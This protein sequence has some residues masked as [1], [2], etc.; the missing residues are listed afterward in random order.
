MGDIK[1][2]MLKSETLE[3]QAVDNSKEQFANSP[4]ILKCILN[5]IMD[6]GEAH[7]SLS[8]Q[9]LNS[10]KVR[11]GLKDILLGPGQLWE[12]LRQQREQEDIS[13]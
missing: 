9:A 7:S 3:Q 2:Q 12:T 11:E 1:D 13:I 4:D 6:A 10:A 8:K 5:A